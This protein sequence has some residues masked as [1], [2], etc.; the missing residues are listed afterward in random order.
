MRLLIARWTESVDEDQLAC[1]SC[2]A[3][4]DM[5]VLLLEPGEDI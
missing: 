1:T 5:D 3:M 4:F 2:G